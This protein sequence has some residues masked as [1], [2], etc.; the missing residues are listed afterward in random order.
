[1][2]A[3][4]GVIITADLELSRIS[5]FQPLDDVVDGHQVRSLDQ[6]APLISRLDVAQFQTRALERLLQLP[7]IRVGAGH[8]DLPLSMCA[9]AH[10]DQLQQSKQSR[11]LSQTD[12]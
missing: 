2:Q 4:G 3:P 10:N 8:F 6:H 11:L 12:Y 1:M 5:V 7:L 9:P